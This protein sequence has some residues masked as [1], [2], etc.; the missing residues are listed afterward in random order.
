MSQEGVVPG[1]GVAGRV[2]QHREGH[3]GGADRRAVHIRPAGFHRE[4]VRQVARL[5][6]VQPVDEHI[7]AR[8]VP[9]D[10]RVI[11]IVDDRGHPHLRIDAGDLAPGG[12][13]LGYPLRDIALVEQHLPLQVGQLDIVTVGDDEVPHAGARQHVRGHGAEG[14]AA[15][16]ENGG[17]QQPPL[18][19]VAEA[20]QQHLTV[21][22]GQ[23]GVH[24]GDVSTIRIGRS[25]PAPALNRAPE[26]PS[27]R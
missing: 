25:C 2:R 9:F 26:P 10:V 5:E 21:I 20:G 11:E 16:Q 12:F 24:H 19:L 17:V 13:R 3:A 1:G 15:Q 22:P 6:V 4:V 8:G 7:G 27:P 18:P 14:S 23:V